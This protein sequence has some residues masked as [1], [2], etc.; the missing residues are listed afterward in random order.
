MSWRGMLETFTLTALALA[1]SLVLFCLFILVYS[2]VFMQETVMPNELLYWTFR[3]GFGTKTS[4]LIA[5]TKAAPLILAALCTALPARLGLV[6]IGG[7][8]ALIAGGLAAAIV[9]LLLAPL[10][11]PLPQIGMI[12]SG[13]IV[14][15][16]LIGLVGALQHWRG[17]NATISS[18]LLYYVVFNVFN[19][20]IQGPLHDPAIAQKITTAPSPP[21]R[22]SLRA[23]SG[24]TCIG[25]S[26]S[27]LWRVC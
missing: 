20:L 7:E 5:F 4:L 10:P 12:L 11:A 8:G 25:A 17:V 16:V 23:L 6:I 22:R 9:G 13:M 27:A 2:A 24:S 3:G 26:P 1:S 21:M 15:A 14:G 19:Y 18:L